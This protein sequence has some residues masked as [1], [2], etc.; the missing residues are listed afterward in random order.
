LNPLRKSMPA[1]SKPKVS[2]VHRDGVVLG[3]QGQLML[4]MG[5][6]TIFTLALLWVLITYWLQPMYNQKIRSGLENRLSTIV[7]MINSADAPIA[8]REFGHLELNSEFWTQLG[9]A[10]Q[11]GTL[12]VDSCCVDISDSTLRSIQYI[13]N[14]YPCA[15]HESFGALAGNIASTRDTPIA[16]RLRQ[17]LFASGTLYE[18]VES[19]GNRQ[20]AVGALSADGSYAVIVSASVAQIQTAADVLGSLLPIIALLLLAINLIAAGVFSRWFTKPVLKLAEGAREIADGNYDVHTN[21][22]RRDELGLLAREFDHMAGEVKR[23]AQL[24]KDILANVSHDL[25]TPLTLIKGYAETV[26]DITGSDKAKRTEQCSIIVDETDRLSGLVNS[27]MELSKV[28]S[29]SEKPNLVE[30]DMSQL[31]FEVAGRYDAVCDQNHWTLRLEADQECMVKADPAM[32]ERVLH[33]L[34]GNAT[35]H[36]G[37]DGVFVLRAIPQKIGCRVEIE[38]HGPGI[39]PV[40]LPYIFDRYYRARSDSGKAGTGLGL[41]ITK[42]ILQQHGFAFGVN[43]TLGTG[44]TFWFE[45]QDTRAPEVR[46]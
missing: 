36:I 15:L 3:V 13:E 26:R 27:V 28:S 19:G 1:R 12:N 42:A 18:I 21:V 11:N 20:M 29:G 5:G 22:R 45:M 32:M 44:T 37:P 31:C 43:S 38:D 39:A 24:E 41:S 14:L 4:F 23:S 34:L 17:Q 16:V 25:R 6:I 10:I 33:N 30:F 35:H 2:P 40:D 8:T 9:E 7:G 46:S